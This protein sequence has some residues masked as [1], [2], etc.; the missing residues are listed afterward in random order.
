MVLKK[1]PLPHRQ[2]KHTPPPLPTTSRDKRL[3]KLF[4]D[5]Y[6]IIIIYYIVLYYCIRKG[7]L[8]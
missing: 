3:F 8:T 4:T 7:V 5:I 2:K 1:N 6:I